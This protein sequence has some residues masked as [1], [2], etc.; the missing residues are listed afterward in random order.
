[1]ALPAVTLLS[2]V[3]GLRG[4]P[5]LREAAVLSD[6]RDPDVRYPDLCDSGA[7]DEDDLWARL[8]C[9]VEGLWG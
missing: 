1:M 6:V 2:E 4:V 5:E 3:A 8:L 9:S 7:R